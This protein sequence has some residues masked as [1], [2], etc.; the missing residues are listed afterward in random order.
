MCN[1]ERQGKY[2]NGTS[3]QAVYFAVARPGVIGVKSITKHFFY[4]AQGVVALCALALVFYDGSE[5]YWSTARY[6]FKDFGAVRRPN[7][8]RMVSNLHAFTGFN[9]VLFGRFLV[10][11]QEDVHTVIGLKIEQCKVGGYAACIGYINDN[12]V[13]FMQYDGTIG[14]CFLADGIAV[15]YGTRSSVYLHGNDV[16]AQFQ[17]PAMHLKVSD[18]LDLTVGV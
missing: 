1:G 5:V 18:K 4:G 6:Q 8:E 7:D 13:V 3:R 9:A 10:S 14:V 15:Q 17:F 12:A 2:R 16:H 11:W